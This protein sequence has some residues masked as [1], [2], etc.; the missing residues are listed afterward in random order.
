MV[1]PLLRTAHSGAVWMQGEAN[2]RADGR[3][4]NCS[5]QAMIADWRAKW[6]A[7]TDGATSADFPF[8]WSQLNSNGPVDGSQY[9]DPPFDPA[10]ASTLGSLGEWDN[11]FP[12]IRLAESRTLALPN[13]FQAVI[14][15]TPVASG[16]VQ[17]PFK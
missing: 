14:V 16:S 15:D 17:S 13:T 12:S 1:V 5:F 2:S 8:G 10:S 11:G 7:A 6:H 4:Y 3:Q 9:A